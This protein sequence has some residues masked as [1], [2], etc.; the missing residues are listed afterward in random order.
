MGN[1]RIVNKELL[2]VHQETKRI[3]VFYFMHFWHLLTMHFR[4]ECRKKEIY[5]SLFVFNTQHA[6]VIKYFVYHSD[7]FS[8][9]ENDVLSEN[10][11]ELR[12]FITIEILK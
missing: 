11:G 6:N 9:L 5:L 1:M 10:N 7:I 3:F 12:N 2:V 8:Y 4:A